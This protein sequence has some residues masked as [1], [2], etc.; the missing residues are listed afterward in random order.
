MSVAQSSPVVKSPDSPVKV[1]PDQA[2][3]RAD[4]IQVITEIVS[5]WT[6]KYLHNTKFVDAQADG[7]NKYMTEFGLPTAT[8]P[9]PMASVRV[10]FFIDARGEIY[11][12]FENDSLHHTPDKTVRD[13]VM[14]NWIERYLHNKGITS[15]IL[16]VGT[17]FESTRIK[18]E[19]IDKY[20]RDAPEPEEKKEVGRL[21][22]ELR[23]PASD[24]ADY[25][26]TYFK[27][28]TAIDQMKKTLFDIF[29]SIDILDTGIVSYEECKEILLKGFNL[30]LKEDEMEVLLRRAD[31][32]KD[33]L[34]RYEAFVP[35]V[36][37]ILIGV[38]AKGNAEQSVAEREAELNE[39]ALVGADTEA[40]WALKQ[41]IAEECVELD[42][43][44]TKNL[45]P[46]Q[47]DDVLKKHED[48]LPAEERQA[49]MIEMTKTYPKKIPY[50]K[51][52]FHL[53]DFRVNQL[54]Q[55]L[56]VN[57]L[58]PIDKFLLDTFAKVDTAGVG[59]LT[60]DNFKKALRNAGGDALQLTS[61]QIHILASYTPR[62]DVGRVL[63]RSNIRL[64]SAMIQKFFDEFLIRKRATFEKGSKIRED[65]PMA[66]WSDDDVQRDQVKYFTVADE[67]KDN[68][69][70]ESEYGRLISNV[71]KLQLTQQETMEMFLSADKDKDGVVSRQEYDD[72]FKTILRLARQAN[73]INELASSK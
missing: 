34:I 44:K 47:I 71:L 10:Y 19:R 68:A 46:H 21:A 25:T 30:K 13:T 60:V 66:G 73:A 58:D 35:V 14:E 15:Q 51:L 4:Y 67:D 41:K 37:E 5:G 69:L 50:A 48:V 59:A 54:R 72:H 31:K 52:L 65:A 20:T 22:P 36:S 49:F 56:R 8:L 7:V 61:V 23:A 42:D 16:F 32:D 40:I 26:K 70:N 18:N 11:F 12:R 55:S 24:V 2:K 1:P 33:G 45:T 62:D 6:K 64:I 57:V 17:E 38:L 29:R 43:E 63:Y 28:D 3:R 53:N 27:T 9:V 39:L